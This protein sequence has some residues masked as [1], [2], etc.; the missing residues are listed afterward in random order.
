VAVSWA[1]CKS[2]P[3]SRQTTMPAPHHSVFFTSR[4]P[5]LPPNRVKA[6]KAPSA[7]QYDYYTCRGK[8]RRATPAYQH[9]ASGHDYRTTTRIDERRTDRRTDRRS[10]SSIHRRQTDTQ[11]TNTAGRVGARSL[12]RSLRDQATARQVRGRRRGAGGPT[13]RRRRRLA[14]P[15]RGRNATAAAASRRASCPPVPHSPVRPVLKV[16]RN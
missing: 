15:A 12:R 1:I 3:R 6:L 10:G 14:S 9:S 2:A 4:M 11:L 13:C 7:E 8:R 5:F 16:F